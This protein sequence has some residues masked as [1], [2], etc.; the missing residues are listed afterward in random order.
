MK[1]YKASGIYYLLLLAQIIVT[2]LGV[3]FTVFSFVDKTASLGIK[4]FI[5]LWLMAIPVVWYLGL[6]IP[7]KIMIYD[8]GTAVF[9][10]YL[11]T[12]IIPIS[13]IQSISL[14]PLDLQN[15]FRTLRYIHGKL[16]IT[17]RLDDFPGFLHTIKAMNPK[18][19]MV[20]I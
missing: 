19:M 16:Y 20:D 4:I 6:K 8:D 5:S 12:V 7:V 17:S 9:K 2:V 11:K 1:A 14:V 13:E 18:I 3:P 10:S 15:H